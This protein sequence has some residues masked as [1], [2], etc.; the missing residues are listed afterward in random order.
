MRNYDYDEYLEE[1][2]Y[3]KRK[4]NLR[5]LV[6]RHYNK[7]MLLK[8][9]EEGSSDHIGGIRNESTERSSVDLMRELRERERRLKEAFR[10]E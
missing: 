10:K 2:E 9:T 1:I 8:D 5:Y 7:T 3:M 6:E 4:P